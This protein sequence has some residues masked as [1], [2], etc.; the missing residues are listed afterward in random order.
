M[1]KYMRIPIHVPICVL[2]C[3]YEL[4]FGLVKN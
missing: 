2:L 3:A 4:G 1:G